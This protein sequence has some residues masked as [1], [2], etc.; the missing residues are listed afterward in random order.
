M[1]IGVANMTTADGK[2]IFATGG[3][4]APAATQ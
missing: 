3:G 4:A 2:R 1:N